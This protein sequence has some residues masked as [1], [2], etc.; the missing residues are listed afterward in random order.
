MPPIILYIKY[1]FDSFISFTMT[2]NYYLLKYL[3]FL[4]VLITL[5]EYKF[6]ESKGYIGL[7]HILSLPYTK[8]SIN[9]S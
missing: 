5:K 8:H 2:Y 7:I 6:L 3:L 4:T 1:L 9:T